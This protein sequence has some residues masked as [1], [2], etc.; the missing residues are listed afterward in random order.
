LR[1]SGVGLL[2]LRWNPFFDHL[3]SRTLDFMDLK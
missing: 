2:R 1:I 3:Q